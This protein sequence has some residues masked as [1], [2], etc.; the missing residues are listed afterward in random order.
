MMNSFSCN[1]TLYVNIILEQQDA[2]LSMIHIN[3]NL[4]REKLLEAE[5]NIFCYGLKRVLINC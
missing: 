1:T 4:A 2:K 3:S 5:N